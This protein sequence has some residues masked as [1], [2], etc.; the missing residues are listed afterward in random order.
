MSARGSEDDDR[1]GCEW[2][3]WVGPI[4]Q[5]VCHGDVYLCPGC[6][7]EWRAH[8]KLCVHEWEP[9]TDEYGDDGKYCRNC[10]GFVD[11]DSATILFP[12]ICDGWVS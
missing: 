4:E 8:F 10:G 9:H 2:C 5:R 11:D 7:T 1:A 6:D 3:S 12:L